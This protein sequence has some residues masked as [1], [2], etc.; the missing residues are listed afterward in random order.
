MARRRHFADLDVTIE[1]VRFDSRGSRWPD[2]LQVES[3]DRRFNEAFS[4][5]FSIASDCPRC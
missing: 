2:R 5:T 3:H 1:W 4:C